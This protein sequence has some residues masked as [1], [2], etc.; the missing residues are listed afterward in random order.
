MNVL[1]I[2]KEDIKGTIKIN[3]PKIKKDEKSP[4]LQESNPKMSSTKH[5]I[6]FLK[7]N[8]NKVF[9]KFNDYVNKI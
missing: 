4:Q 7:K 2:K 6:Y 5:Y 1:I 9:L 3:K 8:A